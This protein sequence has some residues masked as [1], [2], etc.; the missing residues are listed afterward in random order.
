MM[1][2]YCAASNL[3]GFLRQPECPDAL[4]TCGPILER[5]FYN[6]SRGTLRSETRSASE[7]GV[8]PV[9]IPSK[10]KK[11]VEISPEIRLA[12]DTHL[13]PEGRR[14][15]SHIV[16]HPRCKIQGLQYSTRHATRRDSI[17]YFRPSKGAECVP[18]VIR[19]IFT[20]PDSHDEVFLAV[21]RYLPWSGGLDPFVKWPDFG[22]N[23]WSKDEREVVEVIKSS[24]DISHANQREWGPDTY[25]MK[26]MSRVCHIISKVEYLNANEI[27][28]TFEFAI[29]EGHI[30]R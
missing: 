26:N 22:A 29:E 25:V 8:L 13:R 3:R 12:L 14:G 21:H 20:L 1:E 23:L 7:T 9:E 4:K 27:L 6:D 18:G 2:T 17:I 28:R 10:M 11:A 24:Q 16:M 5:C 19:E 15:G 30:S